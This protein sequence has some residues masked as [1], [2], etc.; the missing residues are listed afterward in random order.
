[1]ACVA[2]VYNAS[3]VCAFIAAVVN[4]SKSALMMHKTTAASSGA[5]R[6][7]RGGGQL[8]DERWSSNEFPTNFSAVVAD[9]PPQPPPCLTRPVGT[10]QPLAHRPVAPARVRR[11]HFVTSA[12]N[13]VNL[14][15]S[16]SCRVDVKACHSCQPA[17]M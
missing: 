16:Y 1:M 4:S 3:V 9:D 10:V 7:R 8:D 6:R 12:A 5:A 15:A 13:S 11:A 17:I 2:A 14:P